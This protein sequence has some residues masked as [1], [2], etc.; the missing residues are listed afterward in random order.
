MI[1][2]KGKDSYVESIAIAQVISDSR[3]GT[4]RAKKELR[5]VITKLLFYCDRE[6]SLGRKE[7]N[8]LPT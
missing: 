2:S 8:A 5:R 1:C 3:E 7:D 6:T 4:N